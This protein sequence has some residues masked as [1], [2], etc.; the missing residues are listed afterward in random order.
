M[1]VE[2]DCEL[3][4]ADLS[5]QPVLAAQGAAIGGEFQTAPMGH[6]IT[7]DIAVVASLQPQSA[8]PVVA[9]DR[10]HADTASQSTQLEHL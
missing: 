7:S 8:R 1:Q 2:S 9:I 10:D 3:V 4:G 6:A 5:L